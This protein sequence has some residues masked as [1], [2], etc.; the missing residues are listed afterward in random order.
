[1]KIPGLTCNCR[2]AVRCWQHRPTAEELRE[3]EI[4]KRRAQFRLIKGEKK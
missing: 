3:I 4:L 2:L 1:M